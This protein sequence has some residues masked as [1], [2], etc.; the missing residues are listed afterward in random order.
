MRL[1]KMMLLAKMWHLSPSVSPCILSLSTTS[2]TV[3]A[4]RWGECGIRP[5]SRNTCKYAVILN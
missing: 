4:S 2:P 1:T 5:G 3:A